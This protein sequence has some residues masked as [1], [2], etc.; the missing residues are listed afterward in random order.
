MLC[1][2][3]HLRYDMCAEKAVIYW[4]AGAKRA[5]SMNRLVQHLRKQRLGMVQTVQQYIFIYQCVYDE[6]QAAL[7]QNEQLG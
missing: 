7:S 3:Y 6:L 1:S 2:R 5:I 4:A